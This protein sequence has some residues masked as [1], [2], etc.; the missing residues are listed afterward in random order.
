MRVF[1]ASLVVLLLAS[2]A[3]RGGLLSNP[4]F[5][6]PAGTTNWAGTGWAASGSAW[7]RLEAAWTGSRGA[8]IDASTAGEARFFQDAAAPTGTYT[9]SGWLKIDPGCNPTNLQLRLEWKDSSTNDVQPA[10]V[11]NLTGLPRDA[12]WHHV[13]VTGACDGGGLSFVRA[14][15]ESQYTNRTSGPSTILFDEADLY[16]GPYAGVQYMANGSFER[17]DADASES[18]FGSSWGVVTQYVGN[19]RRNWWTLWGVWHGVLE[20]WWGGGSSNFVSTFSQNIYPQATGAWTYSI[21]LMREPLFVLSNAQLRLEWRDAT[22]TNTVQVETVT[23]LT[24]PADGAWHMYTLSGTCGDTNLFELRAAAAFQYDVTAA[25][26]SMFLDDARLVPEGFTNSLVLDFGYHNQHHYDPSLERVPGTNGYGA[27][28]QP[29]Y[30]RTTTTFYVLANYPSTAEYPDSDGIVS[31]YTAY[32][33][34]G[35]TNWTI[36]YSNMTK[37]GS[38]TLTTNTPFHGLPASGTLD[39]NV[40]RYEWTQPCSNG[41]PYTEPI[42]V[43]Y[44]PRFMLADGGTV[45]TQYL[46]RLDGDVTNNWPQYPQLF[47]SNQ[48]EKDYA[49]FNLRP[50]VRTVFTNESFEHPEV[51]VSNWLGAGWQGYGDATRD[52]WSARSSPMGAYLPGW[53][54]QRSLNESGVIQPMA[55]TGGTY[56]FAAWLRS[57]PYVDFNR[58]DLRLEWVNAS[59]VVVQTDLRDLALFPRDGSWHHVFVSGTCTQRDVSYV[60]PGVHAQFWPRLGDPDRVQVDDAGFYAGPY[61]GVQTLANTSFE[62]G[63]AGQFRGSAW[64]AQ[65]EYVANYRAAWGGRRGGSSAVYEGGA[66]NP[67][68]FTTRISQ[69]VAPGPGTYT[70]AVWMLRDTNF[71]MTNAEVRLEWYDGTFTN[72]LQADSV[73]NFVAPADNTWREYHITGAC[74]DT[75]LAEVRATVM[76]QYGGSPGSNGAT[77]RIDDA[78]LFSGGYVPPL[79]VDWGYFCGG[80]NDPRSEPVPGGHGPFVQIDYARTTTA[81]YVIAEHPTIA[82]D[83]SVTG[84]VGMRISYWSTLIT[85]WL[86]TQTPMDFLGTVEL[87]AGAPFHGLPLADSH[88]VSVYRFR[89]TQ[90]LDALGRPFTNPMT[91]W[92]CPYF[93]TLRGGTDIVENL[94]LLKSGEMANNYPADPQLFGDWFLHKDYAYTNLWTPDQD[95]DGMPDLWELRYFTSITN[96]RPADDTDTDEWNNAEEYIADSVPT[97]D[98]SYFHGRISAVTGTAV[99]GLRVDAPTTNSRLYDAYW[100]TNLASGDA[101]R[102]LGPSAPGDDA[103]GNLWLTVTNAQDTLFYRTGV[104]LP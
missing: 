102:S 93:R 81:F 100:K 96:C 31:M 90:P 76:V 6:D 94:W 51:V 2:P 56:T 19:S 84:V 16:S 65:P 79:I 73:T 72:R 1:K 50:Q 61:T 66:T 10:S 42:K 58:L 97:N 26:K 48:W 67:P 9:F 57:D 47:H 17:G 36:A 44:A 74:A 59:G 45:E 28:L 71:L 85:N 55:V 18:W 83:A 43:Y 69:G 91:I 13:H 23:N 64:Y 70:F 37:V 21:W 12:I 101:W 103:G 7:R 54:S 11:A 68:P 60:V 95:A 78:R 29:N 104:R 40:Y 5:E 25:G 8:W 89:W 41:I 82:P 34:P 4:S 80:A 20:G 46:V 53:F 88:T 52:D 49:Y 77:A 99:G 15:F 35:T 98:A 3:V 63:N 30:A 38:I 33:I 27:F 62:R 92:Y 75:N 14:I 22:Y 86:D 32:Q 39:L 24:V 87:A